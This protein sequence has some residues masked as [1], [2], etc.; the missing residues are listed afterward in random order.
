[1]NNPDP[2]IKTSLHLRRVFDAPRERVFR[3]WTDPRLLV[4]WW[5]PG[6]Y[7]APLIEVDLRVGGHYRFGLR[8][9]DGA[10]FFMVGHYLEVHP[11]E[12][13]V[14]TWGYEDAEGEYGDTL[15][16][17]EFLERGN[18]T[19]VILR[20]GQFPSPAARDSHDDGWG[21]CLDR[22]VELIEKGANDM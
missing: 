9:R 19:E 3:A 8:P 6:E 10:M 22:L 4:Q 14:Y 21:I 15:V 12:K 18:Q 16:T 1:M 17:V 5:G 2:L 7:A 13:L 20:H 11:P